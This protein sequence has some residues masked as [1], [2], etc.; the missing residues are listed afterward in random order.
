[1]NK[2]Q[3]LLKNRLDKDYNEYI[4]LLNKADKKT[5]I[6]KSYEIATI[7]NFNEALNYFFD[8]LQLNKNNKEFPI[9]NNLIKSLLDYEYNIL[10]FFLYS[11]RDYTHPEEY[12][13]WYDYYVVIDIITNAIKVFKKSKYG[14]SK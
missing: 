12:S 7:L 5:L 8:E 10:L 14:K 2:T 1:M 3:Q 4:E 13:F 11:W 6:N 9:K